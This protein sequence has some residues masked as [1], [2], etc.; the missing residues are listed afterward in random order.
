MEATRRS[1]SF[2]H[3]TAWREVAGNR[4]ERC[5]QR[6]PRD[7]SPRRAA[8]SVPASVARPGTAPH[9]RRRDGRVGRRV[10][11]GHPRTGNRV[12]RRGGHAAKRGRRVHRHET[13]C[14][15]SA[16]LRSTDAP[17]E[18]GVG[19]QTQHP[20]TP[21]VPGGEDEAPIGCGSRV[22][23]DRRTGGIPT[24]C[25][26][27][28]RHPDGRPAFDIRHTAGHGGVNALSHGKTADQRGD[29]ERRDNHRDPLRG[30][31]AHDT[32]PSEELATLRRRLQC[33]L[34]MDASAQRA[35][36]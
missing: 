23:T 32:V 34:P 10:D 11:T 33:R 13:T 24:R 12:Y 28:Q 30:W 22:R 5:V 20:E 27:G 7:A 19:M 35:L 2:R 8:L 29:A 9:S 31:N 15:F 25:N 6:S 3:R 21:P 36:Q 17:R 18:H 14:A 16:G 26:E 1:S 4:D